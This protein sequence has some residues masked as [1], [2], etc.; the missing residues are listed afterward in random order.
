M[1]D[2]HL[3][4]EDGEDT[5]LH[6]TGVL[7]TKDDHLL[8]GEV[9]GNR[10]RRGHTSGES[11]GWEGTGVVDDIVGVEVLQL[12]SRRA[13]KHVAHEEGVV[14]TSAD[15]ADVD[16]VALVPSG[17]TIDDIDAA[18][19]VEVVDGTFSV[20]TPDLLCHYQQCS[21][22]KI[23]IMLCVREPHAGTIPCTMQLAEGP[24]GANAGV[25]LD[26]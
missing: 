6:L 16:P 20:D 9:D 1:L 25:G 22:M 7:G 5:L 11:V 26:R 15:N 3:V 24:A 2:R 4:E 18:S 14:G 19:G 21:R 23:G 8:L 10:G 12:L 17:E 13:D